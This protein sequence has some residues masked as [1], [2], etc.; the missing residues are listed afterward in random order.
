[1]CILSVLPGFKDP[2]ILY[3]LNF[4]CFHYS[5]LLIIDHVIKS[6]ANNHKTP[7]TLD[8]EDYY[9]CITKFNF[10]LQRTSFQLLWF[11][12]RM[13]WYAKETCIAYVMY[14]IWRRFIT[15]W[16]IHVIVKFCNSHVA[17]AETSI[18]IWILN[19]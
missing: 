15:Y 19:S 14:H 12:F 7:K 9:E 1:M 13:L 5:K 8:T 16:L 18:M 6:I 10:S 3:L 11:C 17:H 4:T 2:R